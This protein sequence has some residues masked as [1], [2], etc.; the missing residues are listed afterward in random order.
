MK[1]LIEIFKRI[2]SSKR[3]VKALIAA[4]I[5]GTLFGFHYYSERLVSNSFFV[6]P[7]IPDSPISTLLIAVSLYLYLNG[8]SSV[9][10]ESLAFIGNV[11]Y[12]LWSVLVLLYYFEGFIAVNSWPMYLFLLFSHLGMFLQAFLVPL[13]SDFNLKSFMVALTWFLSNDFVDYS[14]GVHAFI[15]S[16]N[17]G[18]AAFTAI[19]LT[20]L[21]HFIYL[22]LFLDKR[23]ER[24][25]SNSLFS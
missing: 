14:L 4:N 18:F 10:L 6:W 9:I 20:F 11:K 15:P 5:L 24:K 7:F 23:K 17:I 3:Y 8:K 19:L 21:A 1:N 13:Y 2:L 12:G 16:E 22:K 25:G